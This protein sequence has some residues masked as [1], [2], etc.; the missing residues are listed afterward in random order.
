MRRYIIIGL[1]DI[2]CIIGGIALVALD[3]PWIGGLLI[4]YGVLRWN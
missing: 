2:V 1:A 4:L 3:H